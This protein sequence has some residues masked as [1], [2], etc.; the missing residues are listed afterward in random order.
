MADLFVL[1]LL[2]RG[3]RAVLRGVRS[4]GERGVLAG[5]IGQQEAAVARTSAGTQLVHPL[6]HS[7]A[8]VLQRDRVTV[9]VHRAQRLVQ[10]DVGT[11]RQPLDDARL[12]AVLEHR[13]VA[14]L[15]SHRPP[16]G[17]EEHHRG[18][19]QHG[20]PPDPRR[21]VERDVEL[22]GDDVVHRREGQHRVERDRHGADAGAN[23]HVPWTLQQVVVGIILGEAP[24]QEGVDGQQQDDHAQDHRDPD[25]GGDGV[26]A[27]V[28][29]PWREQ[30]DQAVGPEHV[31]VGLR[32]R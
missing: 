32:A 4:L 22:V 2:E 29:L 18:Q 17:D 20:D 30:A 9:L 25:R 21:R 19:H 8:L 23:R 13:P 14:A 3:Q 10:L 15:Q 31:E 27:E 1:V 16:V 6:G 11:V 28:D 12:D 5:R 26:V 7:R 24:L